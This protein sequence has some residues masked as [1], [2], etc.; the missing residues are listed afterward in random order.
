MTM[1]RQYFCDASFNALKH[2][3]EPFDFCF[4]YRL[5]EIRRLRHIDERQA[6]ACEPSQT[7]EARPS[8]RTIT[9]KSFNKSKAIE[10]RPRPVAVGADSARARALRLAA[11]TLFYERY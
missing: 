9:V 6:P 8:V 1:K 11:E 4:P 10:N 3:K 5:R 7:D 2:R